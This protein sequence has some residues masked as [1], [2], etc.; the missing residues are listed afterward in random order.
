MEDE[1]KIKRIMAGIEGAFSVHEAS[2]R[3]HVEPLARLLMDNPDE[4]IE[5]ITK[6]YNKALDDAYTDEREGLQDLYVN[7][8]RQ[9]R[10]GE[11]ES[12]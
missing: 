12:N 10:V 9:E 8:K 7:K 5:V 11:E 3:I 6:V 1:S 4:A 2:A